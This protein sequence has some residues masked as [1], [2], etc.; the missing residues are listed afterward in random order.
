[1]GTP[2]QMILMELVSEEQCHIRGL[3]TPLGYQQAGHSKAK[4]G[5]VLVSP[6]ITSATMITLSCPHRAS[7]GVANDKASRFVCL[8][9]QCLFH[10]K[11]FPVGISV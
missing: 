11:C 5:S 9:V 1:M 2:R 3:I 4:A 10:D 6:A 8:A 7:S